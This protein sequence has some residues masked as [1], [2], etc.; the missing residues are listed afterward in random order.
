MASNKFYIVKM[1]ILKYMNMNSQFLIRKVLV[2]GNQDQKNVLNGKEK[3]SNWDK[4][5]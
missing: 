1:A 5:V 3:I 2:N 4:P